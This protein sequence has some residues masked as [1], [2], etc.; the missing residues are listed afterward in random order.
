MVVVERVW[1]VILKIGDWGCLLV[2][3]SVDCICG[4]VG[5]EVRGALVVWLML[6]I[7]SGEHFFVSRSGLLDNG[8]YISFRRVAL[9]VGFIR[10]I[11]L[12]SSTEIPPLLGVRRRRLGSFRKT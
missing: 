1:I 7:S 8:Y 6:A 11:F 2:F 3:M 9:L 4:G 5:D 10:D 12:S